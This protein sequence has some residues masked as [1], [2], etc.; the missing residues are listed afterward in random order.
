MH[1]VK[2][3]ERPFGRLDALSETVLAAKLTGFVGILS[4][5]LWRRPSF[6]VFFAT[7]LAKLAKRSEADDLSCPSRPC[8]L[9]P[10]E[11]LM[12]DHVLQALS[13]DNVPMLTATQL[14]LPDT[15]A[16]L[17]LRQSGIAAQT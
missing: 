8:R 1:H 12:L 17:G 5:L 3:M 10:G 15:G 13:H 9:S 14:P 4:P 7:F 11:L 16:A 2:R 6:A